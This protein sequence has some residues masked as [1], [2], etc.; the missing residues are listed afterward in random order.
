[1]KGIDVF[2][3]DVDGTMLDTYEHIV[4][5]FEYTLDE[6]KIS[7]S[8]D[9][10]RSV[11]G[12][13]LHQCY[14]ALAPEHTN[15]DL[16]A[17]THHNVQQS[18]EMYELITVY[19]GLVSVLDVIH[20]KDKKAVVVTNR[21]RGSLKLIFDHVG[22]SDKFDYIVTKD[23]VT[24]PKPDP[25]GI[26]LVARELGVDKNKIAM[27]GDTS[28]DITA[29]KNAN[30]GMTIAMSHGFGSEEELRTS[31]PDIILDSF[32]ELEELIRDA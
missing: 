4:K 29:G 28:I 21:S 22:L 12:M 5:A 11:I 1:M 27:I 6:H 31:E 24:H 30:A 32:K 15:H 8:R 18:Q 25:E 16:L 17:E 9:L 19:D 13:T 7:S 26:W 20:Q 14:E 23:D 3:F 2:A 10:I